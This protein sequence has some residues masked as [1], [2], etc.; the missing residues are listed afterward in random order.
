MDR[1]A[2]AHAPGAKTP[3]HGT[4]FTPSRSNVLIV[5]GTTIAAAAALLVICVR[6]TG[7]RPVRRARESSAA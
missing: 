7:K 6:N 5:I 3:L 4:G 2:A 1:L